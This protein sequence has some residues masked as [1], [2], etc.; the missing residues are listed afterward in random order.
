MCAVTSQISS[1]TIV[2]STV[3]SDADQRKHKKSASLAFVLGIHR[4][5]VNSP[6]KWPVT[7]RMFPF[8]DVIMP[9]DI[10]VL[11]QCWFRK[12]LVAW[13]HWTIT[14]INNV[15]AINTFENVV[16]KIPAILFKTQCG[17]SIVSFMQWKGGFCKIIS[18][19][20]NVHLEWIIDMRWKTHNKVWIYKVGREKEKS[21]SYQLPLLTKR[22]QLYYVQSTHIWE[23]IHETQ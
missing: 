21:I 11:G 8:D 17:K 12:W 16:C 15:H 4:G 2:Y 23:H 22:I 20:L 10:V 6:H 19:I 14:G 18:C 5:P 3:Y 13:W 1:L 7:R 9:Y